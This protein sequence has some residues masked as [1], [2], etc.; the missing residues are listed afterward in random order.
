MASILL[1]YFG[2]FEKFVCISIYY[3]SAL[4]LH[5]ECTDS[6]IKHAFGHTWNMLHQSGT[7][8]N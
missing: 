1:Y 3:V 5:I 8:I 6:M 2:D 7:L 4:S